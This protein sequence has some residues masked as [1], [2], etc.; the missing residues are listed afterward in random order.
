[1]DLKQ[2]FDNQ[3]TS[4]MSVDSDRRSN[5]QIRAKNKKM[6][7]YPVFESPSSF[8]KKSKQSINNDND[9]VNLSDRNLTTD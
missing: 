8:D 7:T 4:N 9:V 6:H 2:T 5:E 1:M 3:K